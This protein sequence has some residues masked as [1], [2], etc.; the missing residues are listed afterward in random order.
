[1]HQHIM[2][3]SMTHRDRWL[4]LLDKHEIGR[5]T[6]LWVAEVPGGLVQATLGEPA[7]QM[8]LEAAPANLLMYNLSPVQALRQKREG[9]SF[10]S[11]VL[12]GEMT[13]MPAGVSSGWSWNSTCDRLDVALSPD[14]LSDGSVLDTVDRFL[15]R[16]EQ[17]AALCRELYHEVSFDRRADRLHLESLLLQLASVL[18]LRHSRVSRERQLAPS[19]GLTRGQARRVLE[20]I[21]TNLE[22]EV[23]LREMSGVVDLS[24]WHFAR[25][26]KRT[27]H[28]APH[29]YVL[30]RRI[31]RAKAMLYSS[32]LSLLE[33]SLSTGFC[34]QS[35][36][37][38]TFRRMVGATPKEFRRLHARPA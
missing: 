35:H 5:P 32:K 1:M 17:I 30:D 19:C 18:Q 28:A 33:I 11:D 20:Y 8:Q 25:M 14:V 34:D 3:P 21:E 27:M 13:L 38:S 6:A 22:C 15:F 24:P 29:R 23:T 31:E 10:V 37:S 9:R 7:G 12:R 4:A 36:F 16:D 26:F 2:Q